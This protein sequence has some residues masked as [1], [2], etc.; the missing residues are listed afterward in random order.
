VGAAAAAHTPLHSH[1]NRLAYEPVQVK[2]LLVR[3]PE[4]Q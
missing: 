2:K 4:W 3:N 1:T